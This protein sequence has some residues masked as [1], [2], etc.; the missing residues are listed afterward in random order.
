[1][2]CFAG[3]VFATKSYFTICMFVQKHLGASMLKYLYY[4]A[5]AHT[6]RERVASG[7]DEVLCHIPIRSHLHTFSRLGQSSSLG[8][9]SDQELVS[10][11]AHTFQKFAQVRT[12]LAMHFPTPTLLQRTSV[13][14]TATARTPE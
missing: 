8:Q 1:M 4:L 13:M 5:R 9:S 6:A 14:P 12:E 3:D 10:A 7:Q 2:T 11:L